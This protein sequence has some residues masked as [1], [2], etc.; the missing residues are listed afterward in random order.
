MI[1]LRYFNEGDAGQL[2]CILNEPEVIKFLS[3]KIP[4]LYTLKDAQW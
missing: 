3:S 1:T 4:T 2:L